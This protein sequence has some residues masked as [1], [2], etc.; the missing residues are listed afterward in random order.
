MNDKNN[1][2]LH[3]HT[4]ILFLI[5][6]LTISKNQS[7]FLEKRIINLEKCVQ[8]MSEMILEETDGK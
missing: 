6:I 7:P 2:I 1:I 3:I 5:L 8:N 4:F